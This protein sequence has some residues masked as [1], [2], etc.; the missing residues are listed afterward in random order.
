MPTWWDERR[1]RKRTVRQTFRVSAVRCPPVDRSDPTAVGREPALPETGGWLSRRLRRRVSKDGPRSGEA[2]SSHGDEPPGTEA[3]PRT[4]WVSVSD[5][6]LVHALWLHKSKL[7]TSVMNFVTT[8]LP[9]TC[10]VLSVTLEDARPGGSI[11]VRLRFV[12][13]ARG[14]AVAAVSSASA[15]LIVAVADIL[16]TD[17]GTD[18]A[19]S[20]APE[21]SAAAA[22]GDRS[23]WSHL[24]PVLAAIGTGVGVIGFVT[25][26]GGVI[27]WAKL[28]A[29][30]FP[31]APA[32]GVFPSQDLL[33]I[34]AQTLVRQVIFA[35]GAVA[36]L[37]LIYVLLRVFWGRVSE[38]EAAVLAGHASLLAAA[39]M[40]FFVLVALGG[41]LL[42]FDAEIQPGDRLGAW[43]LVFVGALL[44]A[45][46]GS[47]T[48]RFVYLITATF[49]LVGAFLGFV[50]YWRASN[51]T[52]VRAAA[53]IRENKKA[54]A[55]IFVAEGAGRVYLARVSFRR[56]GE[57]D[58]ARSRL[59]GIDKDQITDIAISEAKPAHEAL[60]Q[61]RRLAR[62]LCELQP[63]A[64]P[65]EIGETENC[66]TAPAGDVQP[67]V[68]STTDGR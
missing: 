5:E 56:D 41:A 13:K 9:E 66:R 45:A 58:D 64:A 42:P 19:V 43:G 67:S 30:G 17:P 10:E 6:E 3:T 55:G 1:R 59:V 40:F 54:M 50:A 16:R 25:F 21:P 44:A 46:V 34:G 12:T 18:I 4:K 29:N 53:V 57:F 60:T 7:E 68:V 32:L 63:K 52:T 36:A 27:V 65:P 38:E 33:V 51:D 20:A 49:V 37:V 47:V 31:A 22:A 62:E 26:I 23:G 11:L 61:A 24:A 35:L 48:H 39:G 28:T 8:A 15:A 2:R 14:N